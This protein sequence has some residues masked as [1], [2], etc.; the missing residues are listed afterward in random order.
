MYLIIVPLIFI[1]ILGTGAYVRWQ[2]S[3]EPAPYE[4]MF[5][6]RESE[7]LRVGRG[8]DGWFVTATEDTLPAAFRSGGSFSE[9]GESIPLRVA[10]GGQYEGATGPLPRDRQFFEIALIG[11]RTVQTAERV[12]PLKGAAN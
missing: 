1:L 3:I 12:V 9:L 4:V 2:S 8:E 5:E 7:P 11:G 6:H 10:T